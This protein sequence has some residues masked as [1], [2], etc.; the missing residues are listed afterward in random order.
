MLLIML[1]FILEWVTCMTM[2]RLILEVARKS[3]YCDSLLLWQLNNIIKLNLWYA[4]FSSLYGVSI[5][6]F[7]FL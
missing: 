2:T 4:F 5:I 1:I 7:S 3:I 6:E